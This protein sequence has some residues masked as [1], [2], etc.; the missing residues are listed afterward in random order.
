MA[1]PGS[2]VLHVAV[3]LTTARVLAEPAQDTPQA[4][5]QRRACS[6]DRLSGQARDLERGYEPVFVGVRSCNNLQ[7]PL[8]AT[9]DDDTERQCPFGYSYGILSGTAMPV[10][11]FLRRIRRR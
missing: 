7:Q 8:S 4:S 9:E 6:S 1:H 11:Y 3:S 2:Q 10:G 5:H